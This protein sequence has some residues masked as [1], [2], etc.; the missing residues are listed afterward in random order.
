MPVKYKIKKGDPVV[1]IAGKNKL[2]AT[3][4]QKLKGAKVVSIDRG[5]GKLIVE[6]VNVVKRHTRPSQ[7]SQEGGIVEK[8]MPVDISNV[9]YLCSKCDKGVRLGVKI[10]ESGKKARFCKSCGEVIDKD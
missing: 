5:R 1:V 7:Q 3:Q 4:N 6:N 10:L 2:T 8:A 9:M